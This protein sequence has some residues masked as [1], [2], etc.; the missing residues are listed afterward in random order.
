M[1]AGGKIFLTIL[2]FLLFVSQA[3]AISLPKR[4]AVLDTARSMLENLSISYVLGGSRLG[5]VGLCEECNRCLAERKPDKTQRLVLCPKCQLCSLDCSHFTY[6]VYKQSGLGAKYLTTALMNSM[7]PLKLLHNYYLVDIGDRVERALPGDLL[8]YDGHV[9]ML[10]R[11]YRD[12]TGDV[13]HVTSGRDL[14]GPGLG[15]Q[16]ERR[17]VLGQFRGQLL[18]ILRHLDLVHELRDVYL[19]RKKLGQ[20]LP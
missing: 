10:E 11:K 20:A 1:M 7:E 3:S 18:R 17:I 16:R 14:K 2:G 6:E 15:I 19:E 12:G 4:D 8:V 9:V 13:I 5:E